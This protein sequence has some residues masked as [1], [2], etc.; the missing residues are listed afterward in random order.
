MIGDVLSSS[1]SVLDKVWHDHVLG[2]I[3]ERPPIGN[4]THARLT[5]A[6][7]LTKGTKLGMSVATSMRVMKTH[8]KE[9][10]LPTEREKI[11]MSTIGPLRNTH[12]AC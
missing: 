11:E 3:I 4:A 9:K 1:R 10:V 2:P 12:T 7:L 6:K 8:I 5:I